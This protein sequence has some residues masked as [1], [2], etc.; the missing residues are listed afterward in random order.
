M[1]TVVSTTTAVPATHRLPLSFWRAHIM[2]VTI[3]C[4]LMILFT[5]ISIPLQPVPISLQTVAVMLIGL[6]YS[7]ANAIQSIA[8]YLALG[9]LGLPV[10]A[11]TAGVSALIGPTG[12][13]LLGFLVAVTVMGIAREKWFSKAT[14]VNQVIL[15]LFGTGVIFGLGIS[16]LA[17]LIGL[18]QA[19]ALGFMPFVLP[20]I[21][22]VGILTSLLK[23]YRNLTKNSVL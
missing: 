23:L 20:A 9:A 3:G 5:K 4:A 1:S 21:V 10:F 2:P 12:G 22:K 15:C 19:F 17:S 6:L 7:R 16:W 11:T 18:K 8:S 13:Y 14:W